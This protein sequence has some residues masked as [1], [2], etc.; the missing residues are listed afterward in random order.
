MIHLHDLLKNYMPISPMVNDIVLAYMNKRELRIYIPYLEG[1]TL[2][3]LIR[4]NGCLKEKFALKILV[5]IIN[6]LD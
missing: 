6:A 1:G 3:S 4:R 5:G 2:K